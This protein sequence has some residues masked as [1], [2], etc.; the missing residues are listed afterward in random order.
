[1]V[2]STILFVIL[3]GRSVSWRSFRRAV[4]TASSPLTVSISG[5]GQG[6]LG[7]RQVV[8]EPKG[9][10]SQAAL[11]GRRRSIREGRATRHREQE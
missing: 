4:A 9:Q 3:I 1:M 7:R 10:T 6:A 2:S 8:I 5:Q 11:V